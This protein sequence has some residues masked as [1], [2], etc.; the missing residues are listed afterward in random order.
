M[1]NIVLPWKHTKILENHISGIISKLMQNC[2][3]KE[4]RLN[5]FNSVYN[6]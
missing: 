2:F 4:E 1:I 3:S 5:T 6:Y